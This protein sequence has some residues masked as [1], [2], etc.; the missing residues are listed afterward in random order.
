MQFAWG[1]MRY[2]NAKICPKWICI[3]WGGIP[4]KYDAQRHKSSDTPTFSIAERTQTD[5]FSLSLRKLPNRNRPEPTLKWCAK[6]TQMWYMFEEM[7]FQNS[8]Y[9]FDQC[10]QL[11]ALI[12]EHQY[13]VKSIFFPKV[14]FKRC[15]NVKKIGP[16]NCSEFSNS[17][18]EQTK[19]TDC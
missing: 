10:V 5:H 16:P 4:T 9:S 14:C 2:K 3:R 12:N 1:F 18:P 19:P 8:W 7:Y 17:L 13:A 15:Q 11:H 6:N